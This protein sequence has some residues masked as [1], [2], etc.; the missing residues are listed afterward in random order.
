MSPVALE[1]CRMILVTVASNQKPVARI[2]IRPDAWGTVRRAPEISSIVRVAL[3]SDG[4]QAHGEF[5]GI[6]VFVARGIKGHIEMV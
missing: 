6:P 3:N 1:L 5:I 2:H 4:P